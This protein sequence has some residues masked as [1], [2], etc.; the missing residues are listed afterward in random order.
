[1]KNGRSLVELYQEDLIKAGD[2]I[3][4]HPDCSESLLLPEETGF[5]EQPQVCKTQ[6][7]RY[8]FAG[9]LEGQPLLVADDA[10]VCEVFLEGKTGYEKGI[11]ALRRLHETCYS[12]K[13]FRAKGIC[14][15]TEIFNQL[16]DQLSIVMKE[17]WLGTQSFT[18]S[19]C[20]CYGLHTVTHNVVDFNTLVYLDGNETTSHSSVRPAVLLPEDICVDDNMN[21]IPF[22][23]LA[24]EEVQEVLPGF[25]KHY[26]FK[27]DPTQAKLEQ[28]LASYD[29]DL[30]LL[31]EMQARLD[32]YREKALYRKAVIKELLNKL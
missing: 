5:G 10:T 30:T 20:W 6:E 16:P 11:E 21:L 24:T 8:Q 12:S 17:Y 18:V 2:Y 25:E 28:L 19:G 7:L 3:S 22:E 9:L 23:E 26:E 13:K 29:N 4:Y 1:M 15:T 31:N 32:E 27:E 14:L